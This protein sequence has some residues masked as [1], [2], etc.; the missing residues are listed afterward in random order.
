MGEVRD[1]FTW[2]DDATIMTL[3]I[4]EEERCEEWVEFDVHGGTLRE[5]PEA[6]GWMILHLVQEGVLD[7]D[8]NDHLWKQGLRTLCRNCLECTVKSLKTPCT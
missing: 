5:G 3:K 2:V 7:L 8:D 6:G 1:C 4:C